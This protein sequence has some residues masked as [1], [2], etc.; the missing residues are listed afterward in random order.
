MHLGR[1]SKQRT[2]DERERVAQAAVRVAAFLFFDRPT[3]A[4]AAAVVVSMPI[5][6]GCSENRHLVS[7]RQGGSRDKPARGGQTGSLKQRVDNLAAPARKVF[8]ADASRNKRLGEERPELGLER[9]DLA[10]VGLLRERPG[11]APALM[12][13]VLARR[14]A[15]VESNDSQPRCS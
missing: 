10:R 6:V 2:T 11:W 7:R 9:A 3:A 12:V 8:L 1:S 13:L 5:I 14:A 4:S 15:K